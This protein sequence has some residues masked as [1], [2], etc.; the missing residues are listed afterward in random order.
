[1]PCQSRRS[2]DALVGRAQA[3]EQ[4]SR[5]GVLDGRPHGV[6]CNRDAA[7]TRL[8]DQARFAQARQLGRPL[9]GRQGQAGGHQVFEDALAA[10]GLARHGE[11]GQERLFAA[12]QFLKNHAAGRFSISTAGRPAGTG[13][14]KTRR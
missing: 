7:L 13:M 1:M 6:R 2:G 9:F 3:G 4:V 8:E 5:Q 10:H 11:Q 12:F 14:W